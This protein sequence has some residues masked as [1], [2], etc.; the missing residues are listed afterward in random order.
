VH[1]MSLA[2][3]RHEPDAVRMLVETRPTG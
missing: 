3:P 1:A 2:C